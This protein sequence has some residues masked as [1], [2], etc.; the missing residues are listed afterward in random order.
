M[1]FERTSTMCLLSIG[2][3]S[4]VLGGCGGATENDG[5][6]STN[7]T[8][9]PAGIDI[10]GGATGGPGGTGTGITPGA[11]GGPPVIVQGDA[12]CVAEPR[13]GEQLPLDLFFQVDKS[14]SMGCPIGP[15]GANC[16]SPPANQPPTT[17]TRWRAI[18]D[19]LNAFAS[20]PT[21]QGLGMG[22]TFFPQTSGN[23]NTVQ[24][25]PANY[26]TPAVPIA[27]LPGNA[28]AIT[29]ALAAQ[30][31]NAGTPTTPALT[32]ALNYARTYASANPGRSVAV[33][34]A[35]DGEPTGCTNNTIATAS[36][37]ASQA[38]AANPSIKTFVLGV[39]PNLMNLNQIAAA[40]GTNAAYLVDSGGTDA[41]INALNAIRRN[42]LT[43]DYTIPA[44]PG[45]ALDFTQVNVETR[46]GPNGMSTLVR[47]VANAAAC[48]SSGGWY[49]DDPVAPKRITLC[50]S[51]CNPLLMTMG[52]RLNVLIGCRTVV[53]P[54]A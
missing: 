42:A 21:S 2:I 22:M 32:G 11:D 52:S 17:V 43:C 23:N 40:G 1:R 39:G 20:A 45:K 7:G 35:T 34:F 27:N 6:S 38:A 51:T 14:G 18:V 8:K 47:Q 28:G 26:S 4:A 5:S 10:T 41:L 31:T 29:M 12:A 48:G 3:A 24:C 33:V 50:P 9:M 54:P 46:V 37:A 53:V 49:Y 30:M 25:M 15:A 36:M 19:A 16:D 44:T 13:E